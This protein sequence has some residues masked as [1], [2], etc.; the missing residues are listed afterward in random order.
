MA[1]LKKFLRERAELHPDTPA[2]APIG[3]GFSGSSVTST[4]SPQPTLRIPPG[5]DI[6]PESTLGRLMSKPGTAKLV[7]RFLAGMPLRIAGMRQAHSSGDVEQLK[8]LAHQLKGAAGGYGFS[9]VSSAA[10]KLES[11]LTGG[12]DAATVLE[13]LEALLQLCSLLRVEAA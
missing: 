4:A 1:T 12:A 5:V 7:E 9:A 13:Y 3:G 2:P 10:G 6:S 11:A 8:V